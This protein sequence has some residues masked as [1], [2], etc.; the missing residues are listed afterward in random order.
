MRRTARGIMNGQA[1]L[2]SLVDDDEEHS[3]LRG[4]GHRRK[5]LF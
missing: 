1:M 3:R 2:R 4:F 5:S